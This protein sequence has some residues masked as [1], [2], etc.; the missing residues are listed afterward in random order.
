[1]KR[2]RM[3]GLNILIFI[4]ALPLLTLMCAA[5]SLLS[6]LAFS[7]LDAAVSSTTPDT[8][9]VRIRTIP[10]LAPVSPAPELHLAEVIDDSVSEPAAQTKAPPVAEAPA[11]PASEADMPTGPS[12]EEEPGPAPETTTPAAMEVSA[13]VVSSAEALPETAVDGEEV[14]TSA[15][16]VPDPGPAD[17]YEEPA[18]AENLPVVEVPIE[19]VP[20]APPPEIVTAPAPRPQ[21]EAP[22]QTAPSEPSFVPDS[23]FFDKLLEQV[24]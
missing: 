6:Y 17:Q 14:T 18:P 12:P 13:E 10:E 19:P 23:S 3:L 20:A 5:I 8:G 15:A 16:A 4:L 21:P 11:E 24:D 7:S 1:M 9:P 2:N 22:A